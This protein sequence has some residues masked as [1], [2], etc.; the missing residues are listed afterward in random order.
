AFTEAARTST[1]RAPKPPEYDVPFD[2]DYGPGG[3]RKG[4]QEDYLGEGVKIPLPD[5][6]SLESE[7][8]ELIKPEGKNRH[9]LNYRG[10]S[11]VMHAPRKFA[12]FTA[13]NV[14]GAGRFHLRRPHDVWRYDP[15]IPQTAQVG[16]YYYANNQFDR[17]HLTRYE[18][19]QYGTSPVDA[20]E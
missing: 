2:N 15:R 12:I 9:V 17:G 8:T 7:A 11:V 6:G 14:D 3:K 4:Y 5:L 1:A 10:Y 18:D 19:M 13:A 20:L 16:D